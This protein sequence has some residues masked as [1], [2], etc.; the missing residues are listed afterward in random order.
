MPAILEVVPQVE[1]E[2]RKKTVTTREPEPVAPTPKPRT[3]LQ[4]IFEGHEE[5]LGYTPD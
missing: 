5:Y 1:T 3:L 4:R 2:S